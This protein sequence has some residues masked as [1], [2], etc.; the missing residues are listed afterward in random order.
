MTEDQHHQQQ[1]HEPRCH[2]TVD[3]S[4][5]IAWSLEL[6][7]AREPRLLLRRRTESKGTAAEERPSHSLALEETQGG[8]WVA[9]QP[10]LPALA[11]G[12]WDVYVVERGKDERRARPGLR[13]LRVLLDGSHRNRTSPVAVR[14]PYATKDGYLAVRTWLRTAHAET[15]SLRIDDDGMTVAGRLH[16]KRLGPRATVVLRHRQERTLHPLPL[17][18]QADEHEFV[19]RVDYANLLRPGQTGPY[20]W[21]VFVQPQEEADMVRVG[22]LFDDIPDRKKI[23][24]YSA[25]RLGKR[26]E[27]EVRPYYTVNNDLAIEV[28]TR[29]V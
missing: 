12:R 29:S 19:F 10:G 28:S 1:Q 15:Q 16:G 9:V 18:Q 25:A 27:Y 3:E 13:D 11:E 24:V 21:D 23:F 22:K 2:C 8:R 17:Q 4:G 14:I 20:A 26:G 7:E 5:N 6:P